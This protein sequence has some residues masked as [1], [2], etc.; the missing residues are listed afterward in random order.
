MERPEEKSTLR[1]ALYLGAEVQGAVHIANVELESATSPPL[2]DVRYGVVQLTENPRV[3]MNF[4]I[5]EP[6]GS[7]QTQPCSTGTADHQSINAASI[8]PSCST[9]AASTHSSAGSEASCSG[10]SVCTCSSWQQLCADLPGKQYSW[11]GTNCDVERLHTWPA[12]G[13]A[14]VAGASS[15]IAKTRQAGA[16]PTGRGHVKQSAV[17]GSPND[18]PNDEPK[19]EHLFE[20]RVVR[21]RL[22]SG[23]T[24]ADQSHAAVK[25]TA[26]DQGHAGGKGTAKGTGAAE[27]LEEH[28]PV[29]PQVQARVRKWYQLLQVRLQPVSQHRLREVLCYSHAA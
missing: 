16:P 8:S 21:Q 29:N 7:C 9:W 15:L 6:C 12:A 25:G 24:A 5:T 2:A 1:R 18:P 23:A 13:A 14:G 10:R 3:H 19:Y 11:H 20:P 4:A 28:G 27:Q 22:R 26:E 17:T